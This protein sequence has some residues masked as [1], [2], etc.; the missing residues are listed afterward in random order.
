MKTFI[1]NS[2]CDKIEFKKNSMKIHLFEF[3]LQ[4]G[5][6]FFLNFSNDFQWK[7]EQIETSIR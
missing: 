4:I 7:N 3:N 6:L 5:I 1:E 2:T